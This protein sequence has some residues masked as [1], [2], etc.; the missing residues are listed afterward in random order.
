MMSR[1]IILFFALILFGFGF[2][3]ST[4]Q[5]NFSEQKPIGIELLNDLAKASHEEHQPDH[6]KNTE[7][8]AVESKEIVI[9]LNNPIIKNGH[10]IYV[11][12]GQCITCH[13]D[14]GQGLKEKQAPLIAGQYE[15]YIFSQLTAFKNKERKNEAMLPFIKDLTEQDFKDVAEYIKLLRVK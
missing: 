8:A 14:M 9:D 12:K 13:G 10:E 3:L 6:D 1:L 15:W 5:K 7:V 2:Y 4:Y 11:N